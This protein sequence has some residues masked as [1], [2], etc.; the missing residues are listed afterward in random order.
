MQ[1]GNDR[2]IV[3]GLMNVIWCSADA[4]P[5]QSGSSVTLRKHS[6]YGSMQVNFLSSQQVF[7]VIVFPLGGVELLLHDAALGSIYV[8]G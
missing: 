7:V 1:D 5:T 4:V 3:N 6:K 8:H 2:P